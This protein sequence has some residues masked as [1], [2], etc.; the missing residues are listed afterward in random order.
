M[1]RT[2]KQPDPSELDLFRLAGEVF[3][4]AWWI[5]SHKGGLRTPWSWEG[6]SYFYEKACIKE[7]ALEPQEF[8]RHIPVS[9]H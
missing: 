2:A 8:A 3:E 7:P 4:E 1:P 5:M 9:P 6:F